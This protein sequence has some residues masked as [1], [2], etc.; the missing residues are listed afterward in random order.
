MKIKHLLLL[1]ASAAMLALSCED[2]IE[3]KPGDKTEDITPELVLVTDT[4]SSFSSDG[5]SV[6]VNFK[7]NLDWSVSIPEDVT[8]LSADPASGVA[9][10]EVSFTLTA[11][12]NPTYG[13]R[14]AE[15]T[16]SCFNDKGSDS[17][18]F[19]VSQKQK[20]ALIVTED[21][22]PV[23]CQ[24]DT[25]SVT[26]SANAEVS[27]EIAEEAKSWIVQVEKPATRALVESV[28]YF[29]IKPNEEHESR[30]GV[31]TFTNVAGSET[32][33]I[34][35]EA[36]PYPEPELSAAPAA[37][38]AFPV[39][40]GSAK[41]TITSSIP[42]TASVPE[43]AAEW[44]AVEPL[45]GEAGAQVVTVSVPAYDGNDARSAKILFSCTNP[46]GTAEVELSITQNGLNIP[47]DIHVSDAEGL[48]EF[49]AA[50]N[51]KYYDLVL[52][53]LTVTLDSDIVFDA[54]TS[55]AYNATGGIG[56]KVGFGD[57]EDYY[58]SGSFDGNGF[59]VKGFTASVP[60][61]KAVGSEGKI[62]DLTVDDDCSFVFAHPN[63]G[64][65]NYGAV[66]GYNK[67]EV[68]KVVVKADVSLAAAEV[69][70]A[71]ALGGLVGRVTVGLVDSC[72]YSG[73][74]L[75]PDGYA[76]TGKK[77]YIGGLV[78]CIT[79]ADG[80]VLNS[81][82]EGTMDVACTVASTDKYTP[83]LVVGG[84]VGG[85]N[86]GTVSGCVTMDTK[87]KSIMMDNSKTFAAAIQNH[88]RKAYALAQ[89]GIA[90]QNAGTVSGCTNNASIKNFVLSNGIQGGTAADANS[91][92]YEVGGIVGY[93]MQGATIMNCVNNGAFESRSTPRIQKIGGIAGW[94]LG[95]V[96]DCTNASTGSIYIT[97]TN[98]SPYSLR[99]GEVGGI[100]GDNQ[101][102][103]TNV[104]NEGDISMDRTENSNGADLRFGGVIGINSVALD[105]GAGKNISN[106]GN[107][108]DS[109]NG[110]T[111]VDVIDNESGTVTTRRALRFGGVIGSTSAPVRNV[112][113]SG[114]IVYQLSSANALCKLYMGGVVGEVI[115]TTGITISG[116]ESNG[117]VY[118]NVNKMAAA[119]DG[120][121]IGGIAGYVLPTEKE[122]STTISDCKNGGYVHLNCNITTAVNDIVAG[123]IVGKMGKSGSISGCSHFS[124]ETHE[125][126]VYMSFGN[127][128]HTDVY[129][130][131][132]LGYSSCDI[133]LS[134]C[135]NSGFVGNNNYSVAGTPSYIGGIA[136]Y[137]GGASGITACTNSGEVHNNQSNNDDTAA[138][139]P[140]CGGIAAR[141]AGTDA[142]HVTISDCH[143]T[144]E[145]MHARR[146][147][148][149]GIVGYAEYLDMSG[150]TLNKDMKTTTD[151]TNLC[152]WIGG[153]AGWAV[154]SSITGCRFEGTLLQA[155]QLH[156][157]A[158][159]GGGIAAKLEGCTVDACYSYLTDLNNATSNTTGGAIAGQTI[160]EGNTIQ[161]CHYK[162][163][164][165][166]AVA[167]VVGAGSF[168]GEGNEADL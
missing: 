47:T 167:S 83:Y 145:V 27:F 109:Y 143:N 107:I 132:I 144:S 161:N 22:I 96:S 116:C 154:N 138:G 153:I 118:F 61:F 12:A 127:A 45:Q 159:S 19:T 76:V 122:V 54:A 32:V 39:E 95:T 114:S 136:G 25:V 78:G 51:S 113:N 94:N 87:S 34:L 166:E 74:L 75:V 79:N 150:C 28:Y 137:L 86:A 13:R 99:V 80:R 73:N 134:A 131:G 20:D 119:H 102:T 50:Y 23:G 15:V 69:A 5:G 121:Y 7:S 24:G 84:I 163:T 21:V 146:G 62:R 112:S 110:A 108:L 14:S 52:D 40:G 33:T 141:I 151:K 89:G 48:I 2:N 142:A 35:Q 128:K 149:G 98:I 81:K 10:E 126:K 165:N 156:Q 117:E 101:G 92:Y 129:A 41:I 111:V 30:E 104:R 135:S 152:R 155:T 29:E 93:N 18:T 42:W 139:A 9:G 103:V 64:E 37:V 11:T 63:T 160:G 1:L 168:K 46:K 56:L 4:F 164:I 157:N 8:W 72:S 71:V 133:T 53:K 66:V 65:F 158:N 124:D 49:A 44:L 17:R 130:A 123:G 148:L 38:S 60:I 85:V 70:Q 105:G 16:V 68:K 100:I 91:R 88:T 67:G 82:F 140:F 6:Q 97:T 58:F 57:A 120:D 3:E 115:D 55:E 162:A 90:G 36:L 77:T 125:G 43:E 147:Y 59:S 106:K 26:L 31:I